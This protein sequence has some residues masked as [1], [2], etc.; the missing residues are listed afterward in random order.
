MRG[1]G[2]G[3]VREVQRSRGRVDVLVV[4][5][6]VENNNQP[7]NQSINQFLNVVKVLFT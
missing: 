4:L 6:S 7:T 2:G 1:E 3:D 5:P